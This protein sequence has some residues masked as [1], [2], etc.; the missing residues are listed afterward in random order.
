MKEK[1]P[2]A[3]LPSPAYRTSAMPEKGWPHYQEDLDQNTGSAGTDADVTVT[4]VINPDGT[5]TRFAATGNQQLRA[6]AIR[7]IQ[8]GPAWRY[9]GNGISQPAAITIHFRK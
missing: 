7:M 6:R 9:T 4:F 3:G 1:T 8:N 2:A 5:L